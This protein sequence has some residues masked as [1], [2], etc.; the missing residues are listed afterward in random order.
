MRRPYHRF[1]GWIPALLG[2]L[3]AGCGGA[4]PRTPA[5]A[6][7]EPFPLPEWR[8]GDFPPPDGQPIA[9][10][11][12]PAPA[13]EAAVASFFAEVARVCPVSDGGAE[14]P[15]L[16]PVARQLPPPRGRIHRPLSWHEIQALERLL[17]M[18]ARGDP[19]RPRIM[20]RLAADYFLVEQA[21]YR[22]CLKMNAKGPFSRK[23][24]EEQKTELRQIRE[25]LP[26]VRALGFERC[27]M[28]AAEYPSYTPGTPCSAEAS[29]PGT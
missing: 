15:G 20:D 27:A 29:P 12:P 6:E 19:D 10:P 18:T 9:S 16:S 3:L 24:L 1:A 28:L 21:L 25:Q 4:P 5:D 7:P 14:S 2:L 8:R 23:A 13:E 17:Q 22:E 26:K 11:S